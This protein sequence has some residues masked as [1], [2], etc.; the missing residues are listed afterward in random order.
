M[1]YGRYTF[2]TGTLA[3]EMENSTNEKINIFYLRN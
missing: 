3:F 1:F 2:L